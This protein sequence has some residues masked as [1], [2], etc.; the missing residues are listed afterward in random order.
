[1]LIQRFATVAPQTCQNEHFD[2][3]KVLR[4]MSTAGSRSVSSKRL[5]FGVS[6]VLIYV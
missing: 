3:G 4:A 5:L 2:Q 6:F 1:M